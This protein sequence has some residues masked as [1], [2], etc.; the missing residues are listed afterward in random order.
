MAAQSDLDPAGRGWFFENSHDLL[1]VIEHGLVVRVNPAWVKVT[2]WSPEETVG[3]P[4]TNFGHADDLDTSAQDRETFEARGEIDV[5]RRLRVKSGFWLRVA[6]RVHRTENGQVL[7][8]VHELARANATK[9]ENEQNRRAV[10]LLQETA[11]V[12]VWRYDPD[13]SPDG[14]PELAPFSTVA[15]AESCGARKS[16]HP[17]DEADLTQAW[18]R[19]LETGELSAVEY[20]ERRGEGWAWLRSAW[21]GVRPAGSHGWQVMGVTQDVTE[22]VAARDA[23]VRSANAAQAAAEAKSQFVANMSHEIRTPMNGVLGILHLLKAEGLS[24]DGRRL[25]EEALS[26]AR[27]LAEVL[28]DVIDFSDI[29]AGRVAVVREPMDVTA[30]IESVVVPLRRQA[31]SKGL[32]LRAALPPQSEWVFGDVVR[33]RQILLNLIGNAVKFTEAGGVSVTSAFSGR[34]SR[35]RLRVEV[36]DTGIGIAEGM[37]ERL[38][39]GFDQID[40]SM[41]RRYGGSGLG[42]AISQRLAGLMGGKISFRSRVGEGSTFRLDIPAKPAEAPVLLPHSHDHRPLESLR[43]LVVEDNPTNRLIATKMLEI[44]GASVA[45]ADDG[46]QGVEAVLRQAFDLVMMDI[47]M[48][49]MDGIAAARTIRALP[50]AA[51][52]TPILAVTANALTQQ[53]EIYRRAGMDGYLAKPFS[54]TDLLQE[55]T[56]LSETRDQARLS[57]LSA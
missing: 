10:E 6:M 14:P 4:F 9:F 2:G 34:G 13:H 8:V 5:M 27:M 28:G 32:H 41:T 21:R 56:R 16:I 38:F 20:R 39:A 45:T 35:R 42:L 46:Q 37:G 29:E 24:T 51:G 22:L 55:I 49:V 15:G 19:T 52:R 18:R 43:V 40:N 25:L 17:D 53:V 33:L 30:T 47:Q 3:R 11:G 26:S 44:L 1:V 57:V 23:A 48:P 7:A 50:G 12:N 36:R 31:E 54:P